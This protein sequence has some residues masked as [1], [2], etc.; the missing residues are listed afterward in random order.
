MRKAVLRWRRGPAIEQGIDMKTLGIAAF[1]VAAALATP[2]GAQDAPV[3]ELP[4]DVEEV[5]AAVPPPP[6]DGPGPNPAAELNLACVGAGSATRENS[7]GL[8]GGGEGIFGSFGKRDVGF[9]DQVS[10]WFEGETGSLRMPRSML[11]NIRGG[12]DGWFE[13]RNVEYSDQEITA[14]IAVSI[15]NKP[16]LRLDRYTGTVSISG[17]SGDYTGRC[18]K[19]DPAME[20]RAF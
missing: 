15:L 8:F 3:T 13:L 1:A 17:K 19:F 10:L 11:P 7:G 5:S 12:K 6:L 4:V 16:K 14:T 9:E 2:S 20:T 18:E